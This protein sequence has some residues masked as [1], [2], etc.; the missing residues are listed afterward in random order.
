MPRITSDISEETKKYIKAMAGSRKWS[1]SVAVS[2][3]LEYAI[4]EK[5]RKKKDNP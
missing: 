2:V 5:Q 3:L 4:K 1:F